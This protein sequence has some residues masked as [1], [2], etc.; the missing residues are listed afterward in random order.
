MANENSFFGKW[1]RRDLLKGLG[2]IPYGR[3]VVCRCQ[4]GRFLET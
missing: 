1:S 3:R 4:T 2:G